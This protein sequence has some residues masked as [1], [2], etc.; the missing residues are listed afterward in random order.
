MATVQQQVGQQPGGPSDIQLPPP[1]GTVLEGIRGKVFV[2]RYALRDESGQAVEHYPEQMWQ[3]VARAIAAVEPD[4][5]ARR[6]WEGR[7]YDVLSG[8]KFVPGGR[9]LSGAGTGHHVTY[10]NCFVIPSPED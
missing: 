10:Y 5:A 8:F 1:T 3:R 2:D 7:F 9:I 6:E 4:D